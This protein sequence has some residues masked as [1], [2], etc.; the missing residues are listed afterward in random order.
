MIQIVNGN[1]SKLI[2]AV[3]DETDSDVLFA[4]LFPFLKDE[5]AADRRVSFWLLVMRL[6][7]LMG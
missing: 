7:L 6:I 1:V 4:V 5:L 2:A 3:I